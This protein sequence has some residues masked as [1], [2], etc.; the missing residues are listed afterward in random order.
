[1]RE[2]AARALARIADRGHAREPPSRPTGNR[3]DTFAGMDE[4]VS[5]MT[6]RGLRDA[7]DAG[8]TGPTTAEARLAL[9]D[10]LTREA[11]ALMAFE[12]RPYARQ[13]AP[14]RVR[15]LGDRDDSTRE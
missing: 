4:R 2:H 11:W 3:G 14:V 12:P 9:V 15:R 1:M 7:P 6:L 13:R 8:L 5:T 10:V